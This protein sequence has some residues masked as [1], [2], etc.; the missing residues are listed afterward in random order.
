ML[1]LLAFN[2]QNIQE[3]HHPDHASIENFLRC[4]IRTVPGNMHIDYIEYEVRTLHHFGA[5]GI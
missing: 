1:E 4:H 2:M 5:I 3:S